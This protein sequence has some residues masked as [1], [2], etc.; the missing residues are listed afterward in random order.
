[1]N[2]R[3]GDKILICIS[4]ISNTVMLRNQCDPFYYKASIIVGNDT[5]YHIALFNSEHLYRGLEIE[6]LADFYYYKYLGFR[7]VFLADEDIIC[8]TTDRFCYY[9]NRLFR[10]LKPITDFKCWDCQKL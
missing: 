7:I 1:M 6:D 5:S 9:C 3:V 8:H 10:N 4:S 2:Y